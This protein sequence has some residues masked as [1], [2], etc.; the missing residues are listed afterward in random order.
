[1]SA[2]HIQHKRQRRDS[3]RMKRFALHLTQQSA[4]MMRAADELHALGVTFITTAFAIP[5]TIWHR[6]AAGP[7]IVA[8]PF[9]YRGLS[10]YVLSADGDGQQIPNGHDADQRSE[11]A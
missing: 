8:D 9:S 6:V 11:G 3:R 7:Y 2:R 1:M 5:E 10:Y 4:V